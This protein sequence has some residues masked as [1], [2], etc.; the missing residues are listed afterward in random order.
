MALALGV[1]SPIG[2]V[3]PWVEEKL[4][5][6]KVQEGKLLGEALRG[7]GGSAVG[8]DQW[9]RSAGVSGDGG[10]VAG[11]GAAAGGDGLAST[12]R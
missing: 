1:K 5:G 10:A 11:A 7:A 12:S 8:G 4:Q 6:E 2:S 9:G 3:S